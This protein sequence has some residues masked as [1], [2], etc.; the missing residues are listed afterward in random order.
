[1][2]GPNRRV[3]RRPAGSSKSMPTTCG[4]SSRNCAVACIIDADIVNAAATF[5][6]ADTAPT[7]KLCGHGGISDGKSDRGSPCRT[8]HHVL[9]GAVGRIWV[10]LGAGAWSVSL[11]VRSLRGLFRYRAP[12]HQASEA[13][14]EGSG[15]ARKIAIRPV[16]HCAVAGVGM[17]GSNGDLGMGP[18]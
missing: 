6:V 18:I 2:I 17:Q 12:R 13:G 10:A 7:A 4:R 16:R 11:L 3:Q 9:V 14:S 8:S 5:V 15:A 1:M